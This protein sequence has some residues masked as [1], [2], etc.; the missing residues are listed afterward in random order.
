MRRIVYFTTCFFLLLSAAL[1]PGSAGEVIDGIVATVNRQPL[2]RSDWDEAVCFE[3]FMQQKPLS[4]VTESDRVLALQRLIDRQLLKAQ[5]GNA[6]S[7][8]P[9]EDELR[10]DLAKLRA[11]VPNGNNDESWRKLLA[12]YALNETIVK[13][14][15][16]TEVQVMNF[17]EVR[18]RPNVH[19]Q[20]DEVEAY[21]QNQL[22]PDLQKNGGKVVP[23]DEV[24]PR[25]RELLTQQRMDELLDAWLHNLR[26]QAEIHSSV[27]IPG[28]NAPDNGARASGSN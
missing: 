9:S 5:M 6:D 17:V 12:S 15:L 14:H 28:V 2:L 8:L 26:Q 19:I 4:A 1:V 10:H 3:A 20:A 11:Q 18:L 21:Y 25:I 27:S 16:R 7:M 13:Q 23:F 24:E 22:L